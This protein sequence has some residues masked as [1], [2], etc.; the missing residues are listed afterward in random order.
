MGLEDGLDETTTCEKLKTTHD[1]GWRTGVSMDLRP[2]Q[3]AQ[4]AQI[5]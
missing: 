2:M 4:R 1:G 3:W 5:G